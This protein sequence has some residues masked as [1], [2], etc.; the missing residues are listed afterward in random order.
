MPGL[1]PGTTRRLSSNPHRS[2]EPGTK[3]T[4][5]IAQQPKSKRRRV[6]NDGWDFDPVR[7]KH[8][9]VDEYLYTIKN[10]ARALGRKEGTLRRL[11]A[12]GQLPVTPWHRDSQFPAGRVRMYSR[13]AIE[14]VIRIAEEEGLMY[15]GADV[16][17]DFT[18]KVTELFAEEFRAWDEENERKSRAARALQ[19]RRI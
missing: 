2:A 12:E 13:A 9:G 15:I 6:I 10:L 8:R 16:T 14:G 7:V 5:T 1:Y 3:Y 19:H 18:D 4:C 11:E 17:E